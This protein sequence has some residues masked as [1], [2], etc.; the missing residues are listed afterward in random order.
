MRG[1][2]FARQ[3]LA[4]GYDLD[5]LPAG[6]YETTERRQVP[7]F[8]SIE[9]NVVFIDAHQVALVRIDHGEE[10]PLGVEV[11]RIRADGCRVL[12]GWVLDPEFPLPS[13]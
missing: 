4:P 11:S 6:L 2:E 13:S 7:E 1:R 12:K 10:L 3:A 5:T 8:Y 9:H